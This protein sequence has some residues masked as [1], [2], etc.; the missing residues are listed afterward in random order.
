MKFLF[1][2]SNFGYTAQVTWITDFDEIW[3]SKKYLTRTFSSAMFDVENRIYILLSNIS[4]I[5]NIL[6]VLIDE[7]N[8]WIMYFKN[9]AFY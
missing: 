3:L 7:I 6:F 1:N 8:V 2:Y 5:E 9:R 4:K